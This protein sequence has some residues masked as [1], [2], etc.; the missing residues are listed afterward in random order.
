MFVFGYSQGYQDRM[1]TEEIL[2]NWID[3]SHDFIFKCSEYNQ[4]YFSC[5]HDKQSMN[6]TGLYCD[7]RLVCEN[8]LR[9]DLS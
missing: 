4:P 7:N 5:D 1:Q 3:E 2:G 6:I 8:T 9:K